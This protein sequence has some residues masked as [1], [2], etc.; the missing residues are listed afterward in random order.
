M[1]ISLFPTVLRDWWGFF[2]LGTSMTSLRTLVIIDYQNIHLTARDT[3]A[4]FG[5]PAHECLIHPLKFAQQVVGTRQHR[6]AVR[7][8]SHPDEPAP[9][10]AQLTGVQVFRG[11]PSN[12]EQPNLYRYTQAH[13]SE[14]TRDPRVA[15]EYRTLK[16]YWENGTRFAQEKGIDVR[17]ALSVARAAMNGDH[18]LIILASHDTDLE[19]ALDAAVEWGD[20]T[21][22]VETAGWSGCRILRPRVQGVR[23]TSLGSNEF[24]SSR[25]RKQYG[26]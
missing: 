18:D 17:I 16:Y 9:K 4:P 26:R 19:P 24:L 11:S 25:D 10:V 3:F 21:V 15:V 5:T 12:K 20:N 8:M 1:L 23:H 7:A 14:W 13:R 22:Q 6:L 2:L